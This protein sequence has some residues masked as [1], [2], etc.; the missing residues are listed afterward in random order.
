MKNKTIFLFIYG[1]GCNTAFNAMAL[2]DPNIL[3]KIEEVLTFLKQQKDRKFK[4]G[5]K[6]YT[7]HDVR[8][9]QERI[10][11][12]NYRN[13]AYILLLEL[14]DKYI[15]QILNDLYLL[16]YCSL[17]NIPENIDTVH[18]LC[19][20]S[21]KNQVEKIGTYFCNVNRYSRL[22]SSMNLRDN[23][24]YEESLNTI[25]SYLKN[26]TYTNIIVI[27]YSYG[28]AIVSK[29]AK[30]LNN[31][32]IPRTELSKLQMATVG[33]IYIPPK[34]KTKNIKLYHYVFKNDPAYTTCS[35]ITD[36]S[37]YPNLFILPSTNDSFNENDPYLKL[38]ND[39]N[40]SAHAKYNKI[41][42]SIVEKKNTKIDISK[43]EV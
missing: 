20:P 12:L 16:H 23:N 40:R 1:L 7:L 18:V 29:V 10:K 33:S 9:L 30:F 43:I 13:I 39:K 25:L 41:I 14:R 11:S 37:A 15:S 2:S 24:Y 27:G 8:I 26:K 21:L 35:R 31:S 17:Y 28:G 36:I 3:D 6:V 4:I 5:N 22:R 32:N 42:T 34:F 19:D 38:M